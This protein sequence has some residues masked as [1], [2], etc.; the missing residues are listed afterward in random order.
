MDITDERGLVGLL[1]EV[2]LEPTSARTAT[3]LTRQETM[4]GIQCMLNCLCA[5]E[6]DREQAERSSSTVAFPSA[7]LIFK[8]FSGPLRARQRCH[9]LTGGTRKS[10]GSFDELHADRE[11]RPESRSVASTSRRG[12]SWVHDDT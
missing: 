8:P 3:A 4:P 2:L 7:R 10:I 5:Q 6:D 12:T 11:C 1:V 9:V